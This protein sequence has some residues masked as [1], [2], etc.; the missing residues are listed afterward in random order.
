MRRVLRWAAFAA[1]LGMAGMGG[2]AAWRCW[3]MGA[4]QA[5]HKLFAWL[6]AGVG[7]ACLCTAVVTI[8][9]ERKKAGIADRKVGN[10]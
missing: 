5:L 2:Y 1:L 3:E 10:G 7:V 8:L 6:Y 4:G 9:P